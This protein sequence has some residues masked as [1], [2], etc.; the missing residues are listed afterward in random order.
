MPPVTDGAPAVWDTETRRGMPRVS[1][2]HGTGKRVQRVDQTLSGWYFDPTDVTGALWAAGL[3]PLPHGLPRS[4]VL[5]YGSRGNRLGA[6][7]GR[8]SSGLGQSDTSTV[9]RSGDQN[10]R[11]GASF[12]CWE[13]PGAQVGAGPGHDLISERIGCSPAPRTP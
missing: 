4:Q 8:E 9:R 6:D 3:E 11:H 13:R 7:L 2:A 12:P 1:G 5:T 10:R